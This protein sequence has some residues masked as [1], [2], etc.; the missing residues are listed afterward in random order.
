LKC[1][2]TGYLQDGCNCQAAVPASVAR[3]AWAFC[4]RRSP[5]REAGFFQFQWQGEMWLAYGL[6]CGEVRGVYCPSHRAQR[7]ECGAAT[8]TPDDDRLEAA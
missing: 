8:Q 1:L 4:L 5:A 2:S 7:A 3:R 6:T